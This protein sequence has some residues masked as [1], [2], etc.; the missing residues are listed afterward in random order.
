[1][2]SVR[3]YSGI[4]QFE[5]RFLKCF[6]ELCRTR[7]RFNVWNNFIDCSAFAIA[8][9]FDPRKEVRD[10]KEKLYS[11][12]VKNYSEDENKKISEMLAIV[13]EAYIDNPAQDFLGKIYSL[14]ELNNSHNGQ[15]FTPWD[16][17]DFM[18][19]ITGA[20]SDIDNF[21]YK[22]VYDP[23]CGSGT[24]LLAFANYLLNEK[25]VNYMEHVIFAAQDIDKTVA[26][27]CYIQLSLIGCPGYVVVGDTI[28]KPVL[29]SDLFPEVANQH[30]IWYT[31]LW[32]SDVWVTRRQIHIRESSIAAGKKNKKKSK[33]A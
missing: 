4:N 21:G 23:T 3:Q 14:L 5:R 13:M 6:D 12:I 22:S 9:R 24:M 28:S 16:V 29:G 25:K 2:L 11:T 20:E 33:T 18:S 26:E 31:P 17:A 10:M 1:M 7:S 15:I 19:H 8:N 27:M 30:N 32:F